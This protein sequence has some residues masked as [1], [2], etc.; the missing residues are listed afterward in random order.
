M[1]K[2][3]SLEDGSEFKT[4]TLP[5]G[6]LL[7]RGTHSQVYDYGV[8][9]CISP[10]A[11]TFFYPAPYVSQSVENYNIHIMYTTN[12]DLEL[13]LL[14]KPSTMYR[15]DD[16]DKQFPSI[17]KIC[18]DIS[19]VD[20]CG[21]EM[22][23]YDP[24]FTDIMLKNF[25][26]ILGYIGLDKRDISA[27]FTQYK[28]YIRYDMKSHIEQI[29][30]CMVSN[31]RGV[32]GVPE[33]AIH[34]LHLRRKDEYFLSRES[35]NTLDTCINSL[36]MNRANYNFLPLLYITKDNI[37]TCNDLKKD[38]VIDI[39]KNAKGDDY[40]TN[41]GLFENLNNIMQGL[42]TKGYSVNGKKYLA[43]TDKKTGFYRIKGVINT[44]RINTS[45]INTR[46]INTR[47]IYNINLTISDPDTFISETFPLRYDNLPNTMTHDKMLEIAESDQGL[48]TNERVLNRYGL[49]LSPEYVF[50]K[51]DYVK[52]YRVD[53]VFPR[54]ELG[55]YSRYKN[56]V[57]TR[58]KKNSNS[59]LLMA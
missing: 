30:R 50:D 47:K 40:I 35:G 54:H 22:S 11:Q 17:I 26:H 42:L 18:R 1:I 9:G 36:Y 2:T 34:P 16:K 20:T 59:L 21:Y 58:K 13:L 14:V 48:P 38:G 44:S 4:V 53:T 23:D 32:I 10:T 56:N 55:P 25:P 12:Y 41:T 24:C 19:R 8:R 52:K 29:L 57:K 27:F 45:R 31:E 7:F 39:L 33:I 43:F 37:F 28:S 6:T 49:S 3:Y 15:I 51:G 46:R 5:R